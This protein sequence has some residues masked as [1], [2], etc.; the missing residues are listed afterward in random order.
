MTL[1]NN[2]ISDEFRKAVRI[3]NIGRTIFGYLCIDHADAGYF[4]ENV[5]SRIGY[6]IADLLSMYLF[7]R[8]IYIEVSKTYERAQE[9]VKSG[10]LENEFERL[11]DGALRK[12]E[13]VLMSLNREFDVKESTKNTLLSID[14][15]L[16]KFVNIDPSFFTRD[17][18]KT[19]VEK[20]GDQANSVF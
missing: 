13:A 15:D 17:N 4:N 14:K 10:G 12:M 2:Q 16:L 18:V 19:K 20:P 5:D 3:G 9:I 6:A 11:E 7:S 1:W 8:M